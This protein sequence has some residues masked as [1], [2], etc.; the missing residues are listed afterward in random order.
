[1][2]YQ[3]HKTKGG[4]AVKQLVLLLTAIVIA[5]AFIAVWTSGMPMENQTIPT[6]FK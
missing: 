4:I 6:N 3:Q 1:V 2:E 5:A